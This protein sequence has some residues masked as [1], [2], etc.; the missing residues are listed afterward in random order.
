[1]TREIAVAPARASHGSRFTGHVSRVTVHLLILL[2]LA[3]RLYHLDQVDLRG[4]EAFDI[5][6]AAQPLAEVIR[7]D[8]CCQAYPPLNH[9]ALHFWLL[10]AGRSEFAYRFL[11]GVVPGVLAVALIYRLTRE[12]L[13]RTAARTAA[14]LAAVNPF[15]IWWSQDGHFYSGLTAAC[16]GI[17]W[18]GLRALRYGASRRSLLP[19]VLAATV[20]LYFHYFAAFAILG[21]LAVAALRA[22]RER[23]LHPW[24]RRFLLA[25][26]AVAAAFSPW[27]LAALGLMQRFELGWAPPVSLPELLGRLAQSY[28]LGYTAP[29]WA[30]WT[31]PLFALVLVAGL[32]A[33]PR[34][35]RATGLT[36]LVAPL[37]V[38]W[39]VSLLRP[40]FDDK[41]TVFVLPVYLAL[42]GG[43]LTWARLPRPLRLAALAL[44]L[45]VTGASLRQYYFDHTTYKSPD[46]STALRLAESHGAPGEV[47]LYNFP[48]PA[49]LYYASA[50]GVPV[51]LTPA[52]ADADVAAE[53]AALAAE[54]ERLWLLPLA[55]P[56][57]SGGDEVERW[58]QR[59]CLLEEQHG[60]RGLTVLAYRTP[61]GLADRW[62][63]AEARFEGGPQLAGYL[64]LPPPNGA[65]GLRVVLLWEGGG[66]T[67]V[68][69]TV[70]VHLVG[71]D[72]I[73]LGQDD[74]VPVAGAYPTTEWRADEAVVDA[75]TVAVPAGA[76]LEGA[77]LRVGLYR[78]DTMERLAVDGVDSRGDY[79]E[80]GLPAAISQP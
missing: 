53:V 19:Y 13:P 17:L 18:L 41:F 8:L 58:L 32:A 37:L 4:D 69:Y 15:L 40:M 22:I 20:G 46:W 30:L 66:P 63:P 23:G 72:G 24:A 42:L 47:L 80:L 5:L 77:R 57:W 34:R 44:V 21:V 74:S 61:A 11:F 7:N 38:F 36:L 10:L 25:H 65:T 78:P 79:V 39:L 52:T 70:F 27:A 33:L 9:S 71:P 67:A 48:D 76:G 49:V 75:H 28:S 3:L 12:L 45:V 16:A 54:H 26:V 2:A 6:Y 55:R 59:H 50:A 68:P 35:A 29:A 43:G 73:M 14:L 60:V 51:R 64:V 31:L 1:M 62:L 56:E